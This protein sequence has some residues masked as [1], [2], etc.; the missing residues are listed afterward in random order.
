MCDE[1][2]TQNHY[3]WLFIDSLL[4]DLKVH[5]HCK[6]EHGHGFYKTKGI[7]KRLLLLLPSVIANIFT[8]ILWLITYPF[9]WI[10]ELVS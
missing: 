3:T 5:Y 8:F 6:N 1:T 10:H 7:I 2:I 4:F 9:W